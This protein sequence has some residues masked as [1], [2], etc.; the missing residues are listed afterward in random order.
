MMRAKRPWTLRVSASSS[1]VSSSRSGR[2]A[3]V[4][5]RYGVSVTRSTSSIRCRPWTRIRSVPSGTLIILWITAAVPTSFRSSQPGASIEPSRAVR[6]ASSRSP[7]T[8]S[9]IRR[10]ERSWPIASGVIDCGNTTVSFSGR[11]GSVAGNASWSS[12]ASGGSKLISVTRPT[13]GWTS[14]RSLDRDRDAAARRRLRGDRQRHRQ[15]ATVVA[16]VGLFE[17]DVLGESNFPLERAV[18]DLHLLVH[19]S[20]R[21]RPHALALHEQ[22]ALGGHHRHALRVD[23]RQ[24]DHDRE[25]VRIVGV[26]AV[27]VGAEA[28]PRPREPRH[29][30][31]VG[32]Q[33]LDLL[34]PIGHPVNRTR[35]GTVYPHGRLDALRP[36]PS[37]DRARR[38]A[39]G[40][41]GRR[42]R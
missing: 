9:S 12:V 6:S 22:G 40:A 20:V 1:G 27:D 19:P 39:G 35:L 17:V 29:L 10:T 13:S 18:L 21:L 26:V 34:A 33:L 24:L 37:V 5:V 38:M 42:R 11:S 3:K 31:Q 32:E 15:D 4:P 8:T 28:A 16:R 36:P 30:P 23:T 25:R 7:E 14:R 41:A 2:S